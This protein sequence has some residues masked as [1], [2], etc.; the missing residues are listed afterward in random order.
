MTVTLGAYLAQLEAKA[1]ASLIDLSLTRLQPVMTRLGLS[2]W[3]CPVIMVAGTNGKGSV[4]A[5]CQ[6]LAK[7]AGIRLAA[8][9]SP[10][11]HRIH[12]RFYFDGEY[13]TDTQLLTH[14]Q[15]VEQL[16]PSG[17][18]LTQFE[19][20]TLA[21]LTFFKACQPDGI[22]L[23]V[24]MG[25]EFDA[26]NCVDADVAVVTSI[27][28]DHMQWLGPT[29]EDIA[30]AKAGIFRPH[31]HA[32]VSQHAAH[33]V[34]LDTAKRVGVTLHLEG[35]SFDCDEIPTKP[36]WLEAHNMSVAIKAMQLAWP[37]RFDSAA[38]LAAGIA[39]TTLPGRLEVLNEKPLVLVDVAHNVQSAQR[40]GEW[41]ASHP[42][43]GKRYVLWASL[44]DKE[45]T[46]IV[47]AVQAD[48][49]HWWI[50]PCSAQPNARMASVAQLEAVA[51]ACNLSYTTAST[52]A[53]AFALVRS[54]LTPEDRLVVFGNF[55]WV[56]Q[57][58]HTWLGQ[59]E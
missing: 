26:V 30:R 22:V 53:E 13:I 52:P 42:V 58:R 3:S 9:T 2:Q 25:G 41:C 37:A 51:R 57:F 46:E 14:L 24:G 43:A 34:I 19:Q 7:T 54:M 16:R 4:V 38:I 45:M 33:P 5:T 18:D 40:L 29:L 48:N 47:C 17:I 50:A 39:K 59:K 6:A 28:Y 36:A 55:E 10:H 35:Q 32:V 11:L 21:A 12:E 49:D 15:T 20:L 23:E 1:P 27:A 44:K 8:Y 56:G 31:Q